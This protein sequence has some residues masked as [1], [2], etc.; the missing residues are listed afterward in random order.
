MQSMMWPNTG[1]GDGTVT[2]YTQSQSQ[3][4][5]AGLAAKNNTT[6]GVFQGYGS[7]CFATVTDTKEVTVEDG[8]AIVNG[9]VCFVEDEA[10]AVAAEA[11]ATGF[12]VCIRVNFVAKTGDLYVY[13]NSVGATNLPDMSTIQVA[14][15][16]WAIPIWGGVIETDGTIT[17]NY[18]INAALAVRYD[19][20]NDLRRYVGDTPTIYHLA[21]E[22]N[23]LQW[24]INLSLNRAYEQ[25]APDIKDLWIKV[26]M[27]SFINPPQSNPGGMGMRFN[28]DEGAIY[29]K[30]YIHVRQPDAT[31]RQF[32]SNI[33]TDISLPYPTVPDYHHLDMVIY[34]AFGTGS[35]KLGTFRWFGGRHVTIGRFQY[36]RT[37]PI[38]SI[39]FY[40]QNLLI[41]AS[42]PPAISNFSAY[43]IRR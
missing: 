30:Q 15:T 37:V 40:P 16:T 11:S 31:P 2:G 3:R 7:E 10:V 12:V 29:Q 39:Q 19:G 6:D 32:S 24:E 43:G 18:A 35:E 14:G 23:T 9:V 1:V 26:N 27:N 41:S 34:D 21:T 28:N 42:Q 33:G 8:I 5:F 22:N 25:S 20:L 36:Q 13:K 17:K 38:A 4:F